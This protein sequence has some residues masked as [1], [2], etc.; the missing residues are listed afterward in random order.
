MSYSPEVTDSQVR[1]ILTDEFFYPK[2]KIMK[3]QLK[4]LNEFY[5]FCVATGLKPKSILNYLRH[6]RRLALFRKKSFKRMTRKDIIAFLA[7]LRYK[8]AVKGSRKGEPVSISYQN[9]CKV[10]M[11]KFF[12]WLYQTGRRKYPKIVD[13][14]ETTRRKLNSKLPEELLTREEIKAMVEKAS[15][16]RDKAMVMVLYES[17]CRA[18]EVM[19]LK[20]KHVTFD[21]YGSIII[22]NGKTGMRRMRLIEATPYLT[23]WMNHHPFK[24]DP[25]KPLFVDLGNRFEKAA[26]YF[27]LLRLVKLLARRAKIKKRVYVHL[28]RH[29]RLT[30]LAKNF[31]ESE[32]KV[33][34]GWTGSSYM[35][36]IYVHL[37]GADVERKLLMLHGKLDESEWKRDKEK[38]E[39][40]KPR[41]CPRCGKVNPATNKLCE[42][43]W[44][45]LDVKT[46]MDYDS[47]KDQILNLSIRQ[48]LSDP[49][50]AKELG[51]LIDGLQL[52]R[53]KLVK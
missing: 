22:V 25:E 21:R 7:N 9:E 47:E 33:L 23:Q 27:T 35:P 10:T 8:K 26:G 15:N 17:A 39:L 5:E 53:E 12:A 20:I 6:V 19:S 1:S 41:N 2:P 34:A 18:S 3:N 50:K 45:P 37:S 44:L 40:L 30:E 36:R 31:T 46:A 51:K 52:V 14:I 24:D 16:P 38:D 42:R 43:C 4:T 48:I 11:K 13:W 32:L 49:E 28:F 29:S